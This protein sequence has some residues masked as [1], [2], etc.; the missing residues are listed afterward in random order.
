MATA[1][2]FLD[3]D[4]RFGLAALR[5]AALT[6]IALLALGAT[7]G[8]ASAAKG[9]ITV[10]K[11]EYIAICKKTGGTVI[12]SLGIVVCRYPNGDHSVCNFDTMTCQDYDGF[13]P[14]R[15]SAT[16]DVVG[17]GVVLD[18][19]EAS[20]GK[21]PAG[22]TRGTTISGAVLVLDDSP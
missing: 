3:R 7:T 20:G 6:L 5:F 19:A 13:T 9:N 4:K 12:E 16:H 14:T 8:P 2:V 17:G 21:T 22:A 1:T 18:D 15:P 10:S 11:S